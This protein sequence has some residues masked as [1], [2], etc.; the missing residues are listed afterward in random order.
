MTAYP[1]T[2]I[3]IHEN[4]AV[5]I[6]GPYIS[7]FDAR[8]GKL[9]QSTAPS[10]EPSR[11][12]TS[13]SSLVLDVAVSLTRR[14]LISVDQQ[15]YLKV[16]DL[17]TL[18]LS[19]SRELPKK[20]T[21]VLLAD[22]D[23]TILGADKF[24]DV[25]AYPLVAPET[26]KT[27]PKDKPNPQKSR[28]S[29]VSHSNPS[30]GTL[31]LGH[32]SSL[33]TMLLTPDHKYLITA[34][35]DEHIRVSQYPK[36]YNIERFCLGHTK[37]VSALHLPQH[38]PGC[39]VS[40]GGERDL[41]LWD[42]QSGQLKDRLSIGDIVRTSTKVKSQRR[43]F[44]KLEVQ[45]GA[46]WRSRKR[47]E[48][49]LKAEEQRAKRRQ[50]SAQQGSPRGPPSTGVPNEDEEM[51]AVHD[52]MPSP[53]KISSP[54][55]PQV[56]LEDPD[57]TDTGNGTIELSGGLLVGTVRARLPSLDDVIVISRIMTLKFESHHALVFSA[58]GANAIFFTSFDATTRWGPE[59]PVSQ[60][61]LPYPILGFDADSAVPLPGSSTHLNRIWVTVDS[62]FLDDG[63]DATGTKEPSESDRE[64]ATTEEGKVQP[65]PP[66]SIYLL[67]WQGGNRMVEV[68]SAPLL[69]T[70]RSLPAIP[71]SRADIQ[72]LDLYGLLTSLP[73][74][75][76]LE[77]PDA[78]AQEVA[79]FAMETSDKA[80]QD[81]GEEENGQQQAAKKTRDQTQGGNVTESQQIR[82]VKKSG[83]KKW[84][85]K[86]E[87]RQ[88]G[89]SHDGQAGSPR[90]TADQ[91]PVE[92]GISHENPE[93]E[94][95]NGGHS[96][97]TEGVLTGKAKRMMERT[98]ADSSEEPVTKKIRT[99]GS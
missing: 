67:E 76:E 7:I 27:D 58:V 25:F 72:A 73:K 80:S 55:L 20:A 53:M 45:P 91:T 54:S 12:N 40:A 33:T 84:Q 36:G 57:K 82:A 63:M 61:N 34:D 18:E 38:L 98:D 92:P 32:T 28:K 62:T 15:K 47:K 26:Q 46:G 13:A 24:G 2:S 37:Y 65:A 97:D 87:S 75:E 11:Q 35:R 19:S 51:T 5:T 88:Q 23:E 49:E 86:L 52:G 64:R 42:Y 79:D 39:L 43:K 22:N 29:L 21:K 81:K 14:R 96:M 17:D 48:Q 85:E 30:L 16:W 77:E 83:R 90:T 68:D 9:I 10:F 93:P 4:T 6:H 41:F 99:D 74:T 56:G 3:T 95:R 78:P 50:G 71:A 94:A 59:H 8:S 44:R 31:V 60:Y 69:T 70:L 89:Q 66:N 1:C